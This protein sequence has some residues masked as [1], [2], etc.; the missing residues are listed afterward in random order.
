[1][2]PLEAALGVADD[3]GLVVE[4]PQVISEGFNLV[5]H[6][7]P[8]PIVARVPKLFDHPEEARARLARDLTVSAHAADLGAPVV[9]PTSAV[10]PGPHSRAGWFVGLFD[11]VAHESGAVA[12]P[13][14]VGD[15]LRA[16]HGS[17]ATYTAQLPAFEPLDEPVRLLMQAGESP[18]AAFLRALLPSLE[19][20]DGEV[21]ALHGD[22]SYRNVLVTRSGPRWIDLESAMR[23]PV[24]WDLAE[25]VTA[26]RA[27]HRPADEGERA[28]AAYGPHDAELFEEL[29]DLRAFQHAC[30]IVWYEHSRGSRTGGAAAFVEWLRRRRSAS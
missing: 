14:A 9:A 3:L 19:V 4:A 20:P 15:S 1:V 8:A 28:L 10:A 5:V 23:G 22:A 11:H 24:E 17:L 29:V 7:A 13:E 2:T 6:L 18:E 12:D 21:Q 16:L 25:V 30:F 26:V 27:F